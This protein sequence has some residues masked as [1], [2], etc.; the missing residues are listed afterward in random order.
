MT[1]EPDAKD[2]SWVLER[3][4]PECGHDVVAYTPA[5][6]P[7][8]LTDAVRR[9]REVLRRPGVGRRDDPGRWSPLEYGGHTRDVLVLMTER[10]RLMRAQDGVALPN[11]DQ[12]AAAAGYAEEPPQQVAD[13][14][15]EAAAAASDAFGSVPEGEWAR[16]GV[17]GDGVEFTVETLARYL[18]HEVLHHL[19]DVRG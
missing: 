2:W 6:V 18:V 8:V 16:R 5:L 12:D 10:L 4:C 15:E 3:R 9:W 13:G 19:H 7:A 17:R 14:I 1:I 11:W